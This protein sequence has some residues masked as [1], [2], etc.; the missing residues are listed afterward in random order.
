[1]RSEEPFR[2]AKHSTRDVTKWKLNEYLSNQAVQE[3]KQLGYGHVV[4]VTP[5]SPITSKDFQTL[6][7]DLYYRGKFDVVVLLSEEEIS[8]WGEGSERLYY[9]HD[10][11]E[12][13]DTP[14]IYMP[15]PKGFGFFIYHYLLAQ[16][17]MCAFANVEVS[18]HDL[19]AAAQNKISLLDDYSVNI[20]SPGGSGVNTTYENE[21][22]IT[23]AKKA[24]N[25]NDDDFK[26]LENIIKDSTAIEIKKKINKIL[27]NLN[28]P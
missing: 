19:Y 2:R 13:S 3:I 21:L 27:P 22:D 5:V 14:I 28:S 23:Y 18:I 16:P 25:I 9:Y 6:L 10:D 15:I 1:M 26:S 12:Y 11:I 20:C 17:S 24:N 8:S 4:N 7:S